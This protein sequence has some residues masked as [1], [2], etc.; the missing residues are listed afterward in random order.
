M[1]RRRIPSGAVSF[2]GDVTFYGNIL[3]SA[4]AS[5]LQNIGSAAKRFSNIY[6]QN[7]VDAGSVSRIS[8]IG[9]ST[10]ANIY[11]G[12]IANSGT[13]AVH[14][15][16]ST[17]AMSG[18]TRLAEWHNDS[19][20]AA[21]EV[22]LGFLGKWLYPAA[23]DSS[24]SPGAATISQPCGKSALAAGTGAAG[25]TITNTQCT[26]ASLIFV[27]PI[28]IDATATG[29]KVVAGSGS[30][31]ITTNANTTAIWKFNWFLIN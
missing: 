24:G 13:N 1:I 3:S 11:R 22:A 27:T 9:S 18:T 31:V 12:S 28:D 29:F 21:A 30:F 6:T 8:G 16:T 7:L 25:I 10:S 2:L 14:K 5:G 4:D 20:A 23:G 19:T 17:N 15:Y 26:T